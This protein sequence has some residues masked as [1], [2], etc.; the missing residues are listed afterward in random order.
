MNS[1]LVI[2]NRRYTSLSFSIDADMNKY[3]DQGVML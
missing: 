1:M 2:V 3:R